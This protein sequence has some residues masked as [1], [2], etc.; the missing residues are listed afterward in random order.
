MSKIGTFSPYQNGFGKGVV[1]SKDELVKGISEKNNSKESKA[2]SNSLSKSN[3]KAGNTVAATYQKSE[4]YAKSEE[5]KAYYENGGTK[6]YYSKETKE[7]YYKSESASFYYSADK[8]VNNVNET[9]QVQL[10]DKAK[11][12]LEEMKKKYSNMD[13]FIADY[14]TE[15][16]AQRYL[17]SGTKEY[18][19]LIDPAT[20]EKMA[21][22][23][24]VRDKYF[25]IIDDATV[26]LTEMKE[27]LEDQGETVSRIGI[28]IADDGTTKYFAELEKSTAKQR[29]RLEEMK[30]KHAE[31][32]HEEK[33]QKQKEKLEKLSE[34]ADSMNGNAYGRF[35]K[36]SEVKRILVSGNSIE[37]LLENIQ[38][39]DWGKV[40]VAG[41]A[42]KTS[43]FDFTI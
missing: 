16:E 23:E 31:E 20:L 33:L 39:V 5:S 3:G 30:E 19:V 36:N 41:R 38:N 40:D 29:E 9:S 37:E 11:A 26:Q 22:D 12:L 43:V 15:E 34:K 17:S 35:D 8:S 2:V 27:K 24:A 18:S 6:S 32:R 7:A 42:G 1:K 28:S 10:S 4:Y 14:K 25:G 13:F 21:N